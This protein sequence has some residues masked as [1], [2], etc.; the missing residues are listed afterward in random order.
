MNYKNINDYEMLYMIRENDED[1]Q[2][3]FMKKYLPVIH[4]IA[5]KYLDFAKCHGIDFDDLVQEGLIA[6]NKA[7]HTYKDSNQVLFYTYASLCIERHFITYCRNA[8]SSKHLILNQA[9]Y[10]DILFSVSDTT[11]DPEYILFDHFS[12]EMFIRYK[13]HFDLSYSSILELR[14]NGFS[15]REISQLLDLPISTIDGRLYKI[16]KFLQEKEK[17]F[18]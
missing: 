11:S 12:E 17:F 10:D 16:R 7:I 4:K 13:N 9:I 8:S 6:L 18:S 15:Y 1:S 14:Y 3:L 5:H 2:N